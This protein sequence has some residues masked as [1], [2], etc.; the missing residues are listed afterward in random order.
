MLKFWR[1]TKARLRKQNVARAKIKI[2][3][4]LF[5]PLDVDFKFTLVAERK[6][7]YYG[8]KQLSMLIDNISFH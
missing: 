2:S 5:R 4:T 1:L 3:L 8:P 6:E 7:D